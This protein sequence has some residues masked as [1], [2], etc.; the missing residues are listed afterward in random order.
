VKIQKTKIYNIIKIAEGVRKP[1]QDEVVEERP[2]TIYINRQK[3][4]TLMCTPQDQ[5]YL[6]L[7]FLFSEG[8]IKRKDEVKKI[9][10]DAIKDQVKIFT[11]KKHKLPKY[12]LQDETFTSGCGKRKSFQ[13]IGDLNFIEDVLI[14]LE[15]TISADQIIKLIKEFELKSSVFKSTGGTHSAALA[16]KEKILLFKEDIGRHNAV[17]KIL[18]ESLIENIPLQD[19]LLISSGRVS[20]DILLKAWRAKINLI[21]SRSAPTSLALELAQRLGIT[22]IGFARGKRM[23]IYTYPMR[24]VT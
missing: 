3:I 19:K 21:I 8:L 20:S 5:N 6:G 23:N 14:N 12:F 7:G 22:V 15:F 4:T 13:K 11:Q 10:F 2:L 18:G 24:V 9:V 17:D 16:D 1:L